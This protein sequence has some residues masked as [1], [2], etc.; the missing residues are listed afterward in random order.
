MK[1]HLL[2]VA[3]RHPTDENLTAFKI[4]R[5]TASRVVNEA[6]RA[7]WQQFIS[8]INSHTQSTKLW[9]QIRKISNKSTF[10]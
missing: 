10:D 5:A 1:N 2:S 8:T 4:A 9:K 7:S 3:R 6:K